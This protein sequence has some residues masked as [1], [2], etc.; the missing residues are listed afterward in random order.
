MDDLETSLFLLQL[1]P[2]IYILFAALVIPFVIYVIA[3]WR[4][5]RDQV[6]DPQLGMKVALSFFQ[7]MAF[8]MVLAGLTM[9]LY[10]MMSSLSSDMKSTLYRTAFGLIVPGGLVWGTHF[11]VL[12]RTNQQQFPGVRRL[13]AGYNLLVTGLLGFTATVLAFEAL[14]KRGSSR[15]LGRIGVSSVVVYVTAWVVVGLRFARQVFEPGEPL[16]PPGPEPTMQAPGTP[17]APQ[18]PGLPSLGTGAFP[19]ID[20]T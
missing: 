19:P 3:R 8:H 2:I 18:G 5:H 9:F 20:K 10:A 7:V 15:E 4:A 13:F 1:A 6:V 14:F 16:P 12:A 17:A 11:S